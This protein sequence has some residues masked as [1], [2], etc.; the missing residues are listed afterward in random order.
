MSWLLKRD[1]LLHLVNIYRVQTSQIHLY[2]YISGS[3][4]VQTNKNHLHTFAEFKTQICL[5]IFYRFQPL[6]SAH[7]RVLGSIKSAYKR[8]SGS[9]LSNL[10][11][12]IFWIVPL[13][14]TCAYLTNS[15]L[16]NLSLYFT[17]SCSFHFLNP[18]I[19]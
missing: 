19:H 1:F 14:S 15:S 5:H 17:F 8:L 2:T 3:N 7:T 18:P 10:S 6:K 12:H 16:S 13:N 4:L 11:A 9:V